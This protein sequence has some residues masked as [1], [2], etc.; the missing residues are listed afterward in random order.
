MIDVEDYVT[1]HEDDI[2]EFD[3]LGFYKSFNSWRES[4]DAELKESK[5][6]MTLLCIREVLSTVYDMVRDNTIIK[7]D[8]YLYSFCTGDKVIVSRNSDKVPNYNYLRKVGILTGKHKENDLE[9]EFQDG[10]SAYIWENDLDIYR[11]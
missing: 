4:I 7:S 2:E 5:Y 9:V 1:G 3:L 6:D 11:Q 8:Q 10:T